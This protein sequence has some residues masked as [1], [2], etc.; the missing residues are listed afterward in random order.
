MV[1]DPDPAKAGRAMEA[2]MKMKKIDI[3]ELK[4]AYEGAPRSA[5]A[6]A[7]P[8]QIFPAALCASVFATGFALSSSNPYTRISNAELPFL[9]TRPNPARVVPLK[10]T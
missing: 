10:Y 6:L 3:A 8:A 7:T 4:R 5:D 9:T 2:I 1:A